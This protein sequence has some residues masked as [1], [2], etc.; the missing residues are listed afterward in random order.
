MIKVSLNGKEKEFTTELTISQLLEQL[1]L[2]PKQVAVEVN[3]EI[4]KRDRFNDCV[5][6]DGYEIEIL[7]FVGGGLNE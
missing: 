3:R 1:N 2:H 5:L 6:K 4:I 7:R